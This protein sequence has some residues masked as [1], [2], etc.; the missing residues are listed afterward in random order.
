MDEIWEEKGIYLAVFEGMVY[1]FRGMY[2]IR[3]NID[4]ARRCVTTAVVT[5]AKVINEFAWNDLPGNNLGHAE[6]RV[7][8][9]PAGR[10]RIVGCDQRQLYTSIRR[11]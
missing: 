2:V 9:R 1:T 4:V 10:D 11:A 5:L 6:K 8:P 3:S 7:V